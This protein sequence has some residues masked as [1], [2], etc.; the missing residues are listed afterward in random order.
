MKEKLFMGIDIGSSSSKAVVIDEAGKLLGSTVVNMGTGTGGPKSVIDQLME[1]LKI[2]VQDITRSVVTGYGRMTYEGADTQITEIS[3]HAMGV[4]KSLSDVQTIIDIGGQDAKVI[5][6]D[7]NGKV[8]DFGMNEKCAAGTG[9][10][11][12]VMARV[13][14]CDIGDLSEL[15]KRSQSPAR[16]SSVCTVFAES[17]VISQLSSNTKIEDVAK[18]VHM[19][20]ATRVVGMCNRVGVAEKVAMTGGVALNDD[21]VNTLSEELSVDIMVPNSPQTMGALGAAH[22]ARN[23]A[24]KD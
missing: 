1:Q 15:A 3:C 23:M 13:V 21:F 7:R 17:E 9:R 10:F 11:L 18:G 14:G 19:S 24:E 8:V 12:E 16:I 2:T 5:R 22:Y 6:L 20:V 4:F